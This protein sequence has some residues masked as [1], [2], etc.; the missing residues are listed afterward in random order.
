[1]NTFNEYL[2]TKDPKTM[3]NF[4]IESMEYQ[5]TEGEEAQID[6]AVAIFLAE[7][8]TIDDIDIEM[9]EEGLFGAFLGG[10]TGAAL[11]KSIG[12]TIAKVLGIQKGILYF[13]LSLIQ[14]KT[15]DFLRIKFKL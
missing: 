8:K 11:G 13:Y 4:L 5:L 1:M 10:L 12:R 7:G 14:N 9:L 15:Y 3:A 6:D 2:D